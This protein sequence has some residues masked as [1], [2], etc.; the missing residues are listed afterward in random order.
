MAEELKVGKY[1]LANPD[2]VERALH[3]SPN[4]KGEFVGGVLK[5]DDSYEN[6]AL[7]AEYDRIGGLILL[8]G[9]KVRT[10]SFYDFSARRPRAE[11]AIELEFRIN[12]ELTFVKA[13]D[14]SPK[15]EAVKQVAKKTA[16]KKVAKKAA[17]KSA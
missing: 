8:N 11:A 17:K 15:T 13:D 7:L 3:G 10:G 5:S 12:G 2:K 14:K 1:I 6:E 4:D 9:D 16:A